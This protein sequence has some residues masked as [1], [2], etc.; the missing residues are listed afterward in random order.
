M[1]FKLVLGS[2]GKNTFIEQTGMQDYYSVSQ[3]LKALLLGLSGNKV[4]P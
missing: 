1:G 3:P 4:S 2:V